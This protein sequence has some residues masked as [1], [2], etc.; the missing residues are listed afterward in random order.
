MKLDENPKAFT[1]IFDDHLY[2]FIEKEL[3]S[4]GFE[5]EGNLEKIPRCALIVVDHDALQLNLF[6]Y[7]SEKGI[8]KPILLIL[9]EKQK[10]SV[11]L[12]FLK[13]FYDILVV[14]NPDEVGGAGFVHSS[15]EGEVPVQNI[16]EKF[17]REKVLR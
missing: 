14:D 6:N 15:V 1:L 12:P 5:V 7:L 11:D 16:L 17:S 8:N 4:C 2:Y 10:S 9:S 13:M 3:E